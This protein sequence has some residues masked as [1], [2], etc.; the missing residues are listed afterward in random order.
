MEILFSPWLE[1]GWTLIFLAEM[2][3]TAEQKLLISSIQTYFLYDTLYHGKTINLV[4]TLQTCS[5]FP[6]QILQQTLPLILTDTESGSNYASNNY[7]K[8]GH[9]K[10]NNSW[11]VIPPASQMGFKYCSHFQLSSIQF[12]VPSFLDLFFHMLVLNC[13]N[14]NYR[15]SIL[16]KSRRGE[17]KQLE[18]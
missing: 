12:V 8:S 4:Q 10:V 14:F 1:S 3:G 16:I 7:C 13:L 6:C 15:R 18:Q 17:S 11:K 5:V 9:R 2:S